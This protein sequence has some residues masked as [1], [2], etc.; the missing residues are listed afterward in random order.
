MKHA[1]RLG[2]L[3]GL[4]VGLGIGAALAA[5]PGV[6]SADPSTD[7]FSSIDQLLGGLSVP[8]QTSALDM[9]VSIDGLDLFPTAGNTATA[10]S[11]LGS[12]AIAIGNESFAGAGPDGGIFDVAF[13]DGTFSNAD[14]DTSSFDA[15]FADG[16]DSQAFAGTDGGIF[17]AAVADGASSNADADL[18][19]F[20]SAF[21]DGTNSYADAGGIET[22]CTPFLL[23]CI[24]IY[25]PGSFDLAAVTGDMLHAI[26][27]GGNFLTD[28][29]P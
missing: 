26:A 22:G 13:A 28:I 6:A 12:I 8:A 4:A 19:S 23:D 21:V 29:V 16:T 9:Q 24:P 27:T 5:T 25:T 11:G 18:G 14:A 7:P 10:A 15:A 17:D 3:A 2:R 20:D 1:T